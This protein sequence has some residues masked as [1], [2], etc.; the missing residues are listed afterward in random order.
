ME[1]DESAGHSLQKRVP[2]GEQI[3]PSSDNSKSATVNVEDIRFAKMLVEKSKKIGN[4]EEIDL[5]A[6][7]LKKSSNE[8]GPATF[9]RFVFDVGTVGQSLQLDQLKEQKTILLIGAPDSGKTS[10][11]NNLFNFIVGVDWNDQFRFILKE[12]GQEETESIYVYEI[13]HVDGFRIPFSL[14]IIDVCIDTPSKD[15]SEL[16]GNFFQSDTIQQL[17]LIGLV[18]PANSVPTPSCQSFLSFFGKDLKENLNCL[19][20]FADVKEDPIESN[21]FVESLP[22]HDFHNLE[23]LSANGHCDPYSRAI[24]WKSFDDFFRS[25]AKMKPIELA[26]TKQVLEERKRLEVTFGELR[27]LV[28]KETALREEMEQSK[29]MIADFQVKIEANKKVKTTRETSLSPGFLATNCN[30][31]GVVCSVHR[32]SDVGRHASRTCL[33]CPEKCDWNLHAINVSY[34]LQSTVE[35]VPPN[36]ED[37][38]KLETCSGNLKKLIDEE[39]RNSMD[40]EVLRCQ[41]S[42]YIR[43]L[44]K[45]ALRPFVTTPEYADLMV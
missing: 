37:V 25:V 1:T 35:N 12:D 43:G 33:V 11:I 2:G 22:I 14:T 16:L 13:R 40:L 39:R 9:N 7:P 23:F 29:K 44:D 3:M 5:Y 32:S 34:V 20:A 42:V 36:P 8:I 45:I 18:S 41:V 26:Q 10:L 31:C 17:D 24:Y 15:F 6:A 27:K 21:A 19:W 30:K 38:K 4:L 28:E